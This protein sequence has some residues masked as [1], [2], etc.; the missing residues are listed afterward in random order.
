MTIHSF[1]ISDFGFRI[2]LF[3]FV[4]LISDFG[5]ATHI[6][7]AEMSLAVS[8]PV[9]EILLA[10]NTPV[11]QTIFLKTNGADLTVIPEL[12]RVTPSDDFG[13]VTVNPATINLS[14]LPFVVSSDPPLD[15]PITTQGD[16]ELT[17]TF[18]A[19]SSVAP[20][21]SYLALVFRT[22]TPSP[23]P[24]QLDL[25]GSISALIFVSLSP[26]ETTDINLE[27]LQFDLPLLHD[28][29][30]PLT[31]TPILHNQTSSMIRTRGSL[32]ITSSGGS[33]L[34]KLEL[35][36][37]LILGDASRQ[38]QSDQNGL[39]ADLIYQPKWYQFGPHRI[40]LT[41]TTESGRTI[42]ESE[43]VIWLFPWR[44]TLAFILVAVLIIL[45]R[46]YFHSR[47]KVV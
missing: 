46:R 25:T 24:E 41:I 9:T 2:F 6:G 26:S 36:P 23:A 42:L 28:P 45:T 11:Q 3:C 47:F 44:I 14:D 27:L 17:L 4:F 7:A 29:T 22:V 8:P 39:P 15:T 34:T 37:H 12:H 10:P 33:E 20:T 38:L 1:S 40:S 18:Q 43:K 13:H 16:L 30:L 21:D 35:Y 5:L 31:L 19:L 32:T